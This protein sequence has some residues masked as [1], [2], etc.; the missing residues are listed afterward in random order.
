MSKKLR[1]ALPI[2]ALA[3][4]FM[5]IAPPQANARVHFG[6]YVGP[7]VYSYPAYPYAYGYPYPYAYYAPAYP[8]GYGYTYPG[9]YGGYYG[10]YFRDSRHDRHEYYEHR[11][12]EY[13]E[14][15]FRNDYRR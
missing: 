9:Y 7:P 5:F 12:R 10:G 11:N 4:L 6:V 13:R 3:A 15:R 14:H 2:L 1:I 8:Y